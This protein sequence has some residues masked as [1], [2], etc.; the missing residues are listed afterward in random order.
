LYKKINEQWNMGQITLESSLVCQ[1][2]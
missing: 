1:I 2:L